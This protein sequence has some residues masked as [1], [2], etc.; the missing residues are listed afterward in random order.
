MLDF[1]IGANYTRADV[2]EIAGLSRDAKGGNWDT[3]IVEHQSEFLIFANVGSVG[4][5]GTI[6]TTDGK[7]TLSVG[8]TRQGHNLIGPVWLN[9]WKKD[10]QS[11]FSLGLLTRHHLNMQV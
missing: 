9:F 11:I 2:K 5:T 4:R 1:E 10:G 6:T 3:G 8:T 7:E